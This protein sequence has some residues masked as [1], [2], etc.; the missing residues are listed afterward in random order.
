MLNGVEK[1]ISNKQS[2]PSQFG[3]TESAIWGGQRGRKPW[4][5]R[6]RLF[7]M[8]ASTRCFGKTC[9]KFHSTHMGDNLS[10][11]PCQE[12]LMLILKI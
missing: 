6:S 7:Q 11:S 4:L 5:I 8:A 12:D 9:R 2:T 10:P 1:V 3:S